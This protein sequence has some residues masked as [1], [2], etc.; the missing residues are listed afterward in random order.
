[1]RNLAEYPITVGEIKE[2]LEKLADDLAYEKTGLIGDTRPLL[3]RT[4]AK[5]VFRT[6]FAANAL[7]EKNQ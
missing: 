7:K 6:G 2:C 3:L 1:M 4:A 5:I